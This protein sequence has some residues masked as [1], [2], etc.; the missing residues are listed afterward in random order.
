MFKISRALRFSL[1]L[2]YFATCLG[3]G[4]AAENARLPR[5]AEDLRLSFAPLVRDAAPAVV[6]IYTKKV[7]ETRPA[8]GQLFNDP[9]FQQF[10]GRQFGRERGQQ[11]R[12]QNSLGSGVIISKDG[13]VVT[14]HHVIAGADQITVVLADRR[15][16]DAKLIGSD[17]KTDL[18]LLKIDAGDHDLPTMAFKDSDD[19]DVGDIVLAIGNPFGVGQTVTSG[20]IS[21]L[22]RTGTG[23]GGV[24]GFIQTDAAINPGNSGGAL[25]AM[26]GGLAGINS[27]IFSKSGGSH[28][29]GFAIPANLAVRVLSALRSGEPILSPWL[30]ADGQPVTGDIAQNLGLDRPFGVLVSSVAVGSPAEKAGIRVGDVILSINDKV[31]ESPAAMKYRL[32][33]LALGSKAKL[34]LWRRG[35][36]HSLYLDIVAPPEIPARHLTELGGRQP[37]AGALVANMSPLLAQEVGLSTYD[38]GVYILSIRRGS[39]AH[40]LGFNRGDRILSIGDE[41]VLMVRDLEDLLSRQWRQ[42]RIIIERDG[43][44][45]VLVVDP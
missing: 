16:F 36:G 24:G 7:V 45:K 15:E 8:I 43:E 14:N 31:I 19:L 28:G 39:T 25:V 17:K 35:K 4:V 34:S 40:R 23:L 22:S 12:V 32:A 26:D 13:E 1:L 3:S 42:W 37:L 10:F 44:E 33:T 27:A 38:P 11:K 41:K 30:G 18:A 2:I 9:F 20:I 6:N 21:A 5:D 29:I